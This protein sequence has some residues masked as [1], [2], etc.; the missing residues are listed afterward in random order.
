MQ[1]RPP[2]T[3]E[4]TKRPEWTIKVCEKSKTVEARSWLSRPRGRKASHPWCSH[5]DV[6]GNCLCLK[7]LKYRIRVSVQHGPSCTLMPQLP[8]LIRTPLSGEVLGPRW[9]P[10]HG[11][12]C[13]LKQRR[14][15]ITGTEMPTQALS[16]WGACTTPMSTT[17]WLCDLGQVLSLLRTPLPANKWG[18]EAHL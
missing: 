12:G 5:L 9:V 2:C 8:L 14:T 18:M 10:G 16:G 17:S 11:D 1:L 13:L 6:C 15:V 3:K 7:C 4:V